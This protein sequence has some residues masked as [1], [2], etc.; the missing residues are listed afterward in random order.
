MKT[1][2]ALYLPVK[3]CD[4]FFHLFP[5]VRVLVLTFNVTV[6]ILK[7]KLIVAISLTSISTSRGKKVTFEISLHKIPKTFLSFRVPNRLIAAMFLSDL[8]KWTFSF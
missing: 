7:C 6:K 4:K 5:L 2:S 3:Q 8:H 1:H